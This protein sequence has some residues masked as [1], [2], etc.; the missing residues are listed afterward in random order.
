MRYRNWQRE[1]HSSETAV[2]RSVSL[3]LAKPHVGVAN[4]TETG[5]KL[6]DPLTPEPGG[7]YDD[8]LDVRGSLEEFMY[9]HQVNATVTCNGLLHR[10]CS[11]R[12]DGTAPFIHLMPIGRSSPAPPTCS[13]RATPRSIGTTRTWIRRRVSQ[14]RSSSQ[15]SCGQRFRPAAPIPL[16]TLV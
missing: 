15:L 6:L 13:I 3:E 8:V 11:T 7:Q 4:F 1:C 12:S 5:Q 9:G 16:A 2:G 10:R 14:S